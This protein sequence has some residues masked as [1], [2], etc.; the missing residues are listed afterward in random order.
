VK[1]LTL[2]GTIV[3]VGDVF[4]KF[5]PFFLLYKQYVLN[6]ERSVATLERLRRCP[7][8][9]KLLRTLQDDHRVHGLPIESFLIKPI[10]RVAQYEGHLARL[11]RG[12]PKG[13]P[14]LA[15]IDAAR[16]KVK[17]VALRLDAMMAKAADAAEKGITETDAVDANSQFR[18]SLVA[19]PLFPGRPTNAAQLDFPKLLSLDQRQLLGWRLATCL[20]QSP[21]LSP[22]VE[23]ESI[24]LREDGTRIV[25]A[26]CRALTPSICFSMCFSIDLVFLCFLGLD[27]APALHSCK[28]L[29]ESNVC[30]NVPRDI[31]VDTLL[32]RGARFPHFD[33]FFTVHTSTSLTVKEN[34][35]YG[36]DAE[37]SKSSNT[38]L[39]TRELTVEKRCFLPTARTREQLLPARLCLCLPTP[40]AL[41]QV[42]QEL[43]PSSRAVKLPGALSYLPRP[44][45]IGPRKQPKASFDGLRLL[46]GGHLWRMALLRR[47][48]AVKR[49]PGWERQ[50]LTSRLK[51]A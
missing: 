40:M 48:S 31:V 9:N 24:E 32:V 4:A 45:P 50:F 22:Q 15:V 13:S 38:F 43:R 44:M 7:E 26:S 51:A 14:V 47:P 17:L 11:L 49:A 36:T 46:R 6:F 35:I 42:Q 12:P 34:Y 21:T 28:N 1:R 29:P 8:L 5:A 16:R 39:A 23:K 20:P 33:H 37:K 25:R 19:S 2:G 3:A 18:N 27:F 10:Q 41:L 30:E